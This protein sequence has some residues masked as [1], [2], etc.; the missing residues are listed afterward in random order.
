MKNVMNFMQ[1]KRDMLQEKECKPKNQLKQI[2]D[3]EGDVQFIESAF[4][5]MQAANSHMQEQWLAEKERR[6][7]SEEEKEELQK[8][9]DRLRF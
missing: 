8:N 2:K 7:K 5:R 3:M 9:Y 1:F 6:E 4:E